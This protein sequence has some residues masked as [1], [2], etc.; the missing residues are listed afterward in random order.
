MKSSEVTNLSRRNKLLTVLALGLWLLVA[1]APLGAQFGLPT[2]TQYA[3]PGAPSSS[4]PRPSKDEFKSKLLEAPWKVGS[5]RLSPWLG[6]QDAAFVNDLN[7]LS[8]VENDD[9]TMTVGAGLRGY[10]PAGPKV[11]FAAH[12]LP[13]YVWW[14]DDA[15]K[16]SLNGRYGL[17]MFVLFNRMTLE[18][19]QRQSAQQGYFSSEIQTL[20]TSRYD[21]STFSLDVEVTPN[22]SLFGLATRREQRNEED[23]NVTFSALDR[24]EEVKSIGLS[25]EDS[26]GWELGLSYAS[27]STDFASDARTLSNS[28]SSQYATVGLDRPG[29]GFRLTL[30]NNDREAEEGSEFGDFDES[31]GAFDV[32]WEPHQRVSLLGYVRRDQT[33]SVDGS[34]SQIVAMRQGGRVNFDLSQAVLGLYAEAGEDDF[35]ATSAEA[36][37]R[38]DEVTAYGADLQFKLKGTSVSVRALRT[39]YDSNLDGFDREITSVNFGLKLEAISRFTSEVIERLSL[40]D[41]KTDW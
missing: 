20:T 13:E 34:Y 22:L 37:K 40:G 24:T 26:W 6:L 8:Q 32:V 38:F 27:V 28:G 31:T 10:L 14:Q 16:R 23:E 9:F 35:V 1:A 29:I 25:Y 17:G 33:Y 5:L 18:L 39:E 21:T 15:D 4:R 30:A 19:S 41:G 36:A 7:N 3:T 2:S 11:L 12:A